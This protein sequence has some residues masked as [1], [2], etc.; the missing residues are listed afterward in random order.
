L[1]TIVGDTPSSRTTDYQN[2]GDFLPDTVNADIDRVVVLVKQVEDIANRVLSFQNSQQGA[3]GL[4]LP[5]P[6]ALQY[7]QWKADLSGVQNSIS[8]IVTALVYD[9]SVIYPLSFPVIGSDGFTYHSAIVNGPGTVAGVVDPVGDVTGTWTE[10]TIKS[11]GN[12]VI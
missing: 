12:A 11:S 5:A 6:A 2:N 1:V 10:P 8:T 7:L 3:S 4:T 9:S